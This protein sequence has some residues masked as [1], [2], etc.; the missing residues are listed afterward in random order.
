[1]IVRAPLKFSEIQIQQFIHSKA[2]WIEKITWQQK[3]REILQIPEK[4][5]TDSAIPFFGK[6]YS[7][8]WVDHKSP[9]MKEYC[10]LPRLWQGEQASRK[11]IR[12]FKAEAKIFLTQRTKEWSDYYAIPFQSVTITSAKKR[13]GSCNRKKELRYTWRIMMLPP[14]LIDYIILHELA[15]IKVHSHN[16]DF[17]ALIMQWLPDLLTLKK[18]FQRFLIA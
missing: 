9:V 11:L 16:K 3:N 14:E 5:E 10:N 13:L 18:E 6:R 1:M 8:R 12:W 7:V 4:I 15:H 2:S 17:W